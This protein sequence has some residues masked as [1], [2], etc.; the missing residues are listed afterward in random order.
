LP[1]LRIASITYKDLDFTLDRRYC[2]KSFLCHSDAWGIPYDLSIPYILVFDSCDSFLNH[3]RRAQRILKIE[4]EQSEE[5]MK[6]VYDEFMAIIKEHNS[7]IT[8]E[9]VLA[10][11][12]ND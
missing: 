6:V 1:P 3:Y 9:E 5:E 2:W 12:D 8:R 11:T 4:Y 10:M 7:I